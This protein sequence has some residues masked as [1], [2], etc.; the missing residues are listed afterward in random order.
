MTFSELAQTLETEHN[1]LMSKMKKAIKS[2]AEKH[3]GG[4]PLSRRLGKSESY[5]PN[6]IT[7]KQSMTA[8][9]KGVQAIDAMFKGAKQ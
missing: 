5:I 6:L 4:R 8:L 7:E 3:G 1:A 9:L 2:A